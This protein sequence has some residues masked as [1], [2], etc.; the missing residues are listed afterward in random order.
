[1]FMPERLV[2]MNSCYSDLLRL[3]N[4]SSSISIVSHINPDGDNLGSLL[5]FGLS[6]IAYGKSVDLVEPDIIPEDYRFLPGIEKLSGY[7]EQRENIDL[8]IVL[9][10]SDPTRLGDNEHLINSAKVV[11]NIDHHISNSQFGDLNIIDTKA[12]ST[13]EIV[14]IAI[15]K[16]KLPMD[17][18]IATCIYTAISTDTG[19]FS[20]QSVTQETHRIAAKLY[21]LGIDGYD[22]NRNLYQNRSLK[23]TRLFAIALSEMK[24]LF[25][26]RV[27]VV[28]VTQKMLE[29]SGASMEDTEGIVE[30][31]RDTDSVEAAC[32]LKEIKTE[33]VKAS[34]RTKETIDANAICSA[35][36]GGGHIR[37]SGCT[38]NADTTEAEKLVV[39]E[40]SKYI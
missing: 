1:M 12:S 9:D 29:D 6:L 7:G 39:D 25:D 14:F 18:K 20:Y 8:L 38:L 17:D 19:R 21:E 32:L 22:I 15:E 13:G 27:A 4:N 5:G 23:R 31:L 37:A 33:V 26:G 30:F 2:W 16:L 28:T 40:I 35:F 24:L 34:I 3:I 10:S 36:G 11:V